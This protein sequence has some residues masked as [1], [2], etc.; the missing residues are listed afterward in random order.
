VTNTCYGNP[1]EPPGDGRAGAVMLVLYA[2]LN[3]NCAIVIVR[4]A[5]RRGD[6]PLDRDPPSCNLSLKALARN[7][8]CRIAGIASSDAFSALSLIAAGRLHA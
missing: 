4:S 6:A 2:A 3:E 7:L 8:Q 1:R 5:H